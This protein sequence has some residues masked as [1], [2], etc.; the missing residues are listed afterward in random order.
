MAVGIKET[1]DC[2]DFGISVANG[3]KQAKAD[4]KYDVLDLQYLIGPGL[5][6]QAALEGITAVG[7]EAGDLDESELEQIKAKVLSSGLL[8]SEKEGEW[9]DVAAELCKVGIEVVLVIKKIL[10][11]V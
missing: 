3:L 8:T 1:L 5:K 6:V 10:A 4:N 9:L 7:I 2:L 11:L